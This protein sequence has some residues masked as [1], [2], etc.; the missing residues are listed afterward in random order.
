MSCGQRW[1]WTSNYKKFG[2]T[3]GVK[4]LGE[5]YF[6]DGKFIPWEF[7]MKVHD[8]YSNLS[9]DGARD[10]VYDLYQ[11]YLKGGENK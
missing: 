6:Y 1:R 2:F 9:Y 5:G 3:T 8:D 10:R 4:D 7:W 11:L